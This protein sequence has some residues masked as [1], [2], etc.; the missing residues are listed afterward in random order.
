MPSSW[1]PRHEHVQEVIG[2][3]FDLPVF[4]FFGLSLP[5]RDWL[6]LEWTAWLFV[7]AILLLRRLPVWLLLGRLLPSLRDGR[8]AG[9]NGWF[10]PIGVAALFYAAE[11]THMTG[12]DRIWTIGSLIVFA[13]ILT[14]GISATPLIEAYGKLVARRRN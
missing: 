13:S 12:L 1:D 2:R 6:E 14:H 9:F 7:P 11:A 3:F 8:E 5:W 4:I 10:G